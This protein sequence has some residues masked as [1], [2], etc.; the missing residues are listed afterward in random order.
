MACA[1]HVPWNAPSGI[2]DVKAV[3]MD[4]FALDLFSGAISEVICLG[5]SD[6]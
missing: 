2:G 3:V 1:A 4:T 6:E 5:D